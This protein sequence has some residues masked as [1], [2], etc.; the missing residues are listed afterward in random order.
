[1]KRLFL[2]IIIILICL[3]MGGV[4]IATT[5][6]S[7]TDNLNVRDGADIG[8]NK[9]GTISK[10]S[11][12][13]IIDK[14]GTWYKIQYNNSV[15]YVTENF[16]KVDDS[17]STNVIEESQDST[18]EST[19]VEDNRS[20]NTISQSKQKLEKQTTLYILPLINS[21]KLSTLEEGTEISVISNNGKWLY[22]QTDKESGWI[23]S[24]MHFAEVK[25]EQKNKKEDEEKN[26]VNEV[27]N[28][29]ELKNEVVNN[30]TS[31]NTTENETVGNESSEYPKTMY[32]SVDSANIR[33]SPSSTGEVIS[34]TAKGESLKVIGKEGEWYKVSNEDGVG[35]IR[36]DLISEKKN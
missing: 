22:V 5:G 8:A 14:D 18:E 1:M 13:N 24:D 27:T 6:I 25:V 19:D 26:I 33:K 29:T 35:Y 11:T 10:N 32:V 30:T 12:V 34:G 23:T 31:E 7:T 15:G 21:L 9:I 20:T 16:V 17:Y 3:V 36:G 2:T 28:T 4:V